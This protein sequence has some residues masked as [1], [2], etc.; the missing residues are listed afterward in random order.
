MPLEE[1]SLT[2]RKG[3]RTVL[4]LLKKSKKTKNGNPL[5]IRAVAS[6]VVS[7]TQPG[8]TAGS[9]ITTIDASQPAQSSPILASK[10]FRSH[11]QVTSSL[12]PSASSDQQLATTLPTKHPLIA[13]NSAAGSALQTAQA[14]STSYDASAALTAEA[15]ELP[16]ID[17]HSSLGSLAVPCTED[18]RVDPRSQSRDMTSHQ[19]SADENMKFWDE[20]YD[21]LKEQD[22]ELTRAYEKILSHDYGLGIDA[23]AADE[24]LIEQND[25]AKRRMQ[26]DRILE[27]VLDKTMKPNGVGQKFEDAISVVLSLKDAI[28]FGLQ[29]VPIAALAWTGA[30]MGLQ[31]NYYPTVPN[32]LSLSLTM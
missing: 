30:C 15:V 27:K 25:W 18:T 16:V 1:S 21:K 32:Y 31:V 17:N 23:K 20:A 28:G 4:S 26:M 29:P 8:N 19:T 10:E 2:P 6:P 11:E 12:G 24:N 22:P 5:G 7:A 13:G 9:S 3:F 14:G